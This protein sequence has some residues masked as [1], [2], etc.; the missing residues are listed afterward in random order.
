MTPLLPPSLPC[1]VQPPPLLKKPKIYLLSFFSVAICDKRLARG[2]RHYLQAE[3][4]D[5]CTSQPIGNNSLSFRIGQ[6]RGCGGRTGPLGTPAVEVL[7][8]RSRLSWRDKRGGVPD[9][10]DL[11]LGLVPHTCDPSW[12]PLFNSAATQVGGKSWPNPLEASYRFCLQSYTLQSQS[13]HALLVA[14][15]LHSAKTS[16]LSSMTCLS[17]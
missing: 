8:S 11:G 3:P 1:R 12:L 13:W 5:R 9:G 15:P 6:H 10:T 17:P 4:Y 16:G 2:W 7:Q 14:L